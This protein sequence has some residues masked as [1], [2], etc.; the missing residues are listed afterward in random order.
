VSLSARPNFRILGPRFQK[1]SQAAADAL[2]GLSQEALQAFRR[3]E[4]VAVKVQ[5][6][7]V[8]VEPDWMEVVEEA[9]GDLVVKTENGHT[10][11][12]D[13]TLDDE[14][15]T[16][17]MARELVNRIQRLR[18]EAGLEITDRIRLGVEG[19]GGV[20]EAARHFRDFIAGE[21]LAVELA[22]GASA[23]EGL[24]SVLEDEV[25]GVPMKV[26]LARAT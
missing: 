3:G 13:P 5:G 20:E 16:E 4:P 10:V 18:R 21:T 1:G 12:L 8:S 24:A 2:R 11:A 23:V 7:T 17:G 9:A 14:L 22:T 6:I 15:R 19:S 25:D 26:A